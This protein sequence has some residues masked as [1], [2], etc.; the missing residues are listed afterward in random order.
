ML[1]FPETPCWSIISAWSP[2]AGTLNGPPS[3]AVSVKHF[4]PRRPSSLS[5]VLG[6]SAFGASFATPSVV[7]PRLLPAWPLANVVAVSVVPPLSPGSYQGDD[8]T[9]CSI[10]STTRCGQAQ[11]VACDPREQCFQHPF[12][13]PP[14]DDALL[15]PSALKYGCPHRCPAV[16]DPPRATTC[17][18]RP[19]SARRKALTSR[20]W[21]SERLFSRRLHLV[22]G[23]VSPNLRTRAARRSAA[24]RGNCPPLFPVNGNGARRG[25]RHFQR[26]SLSSSDGTTAAPYA[27]GDTPAVAACEL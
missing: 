13:P 24:E 15:S 23:A 27:H 16:I 26:S 8:V 19:R 4:R 14:D 25:L 5:S 11:Y 6:E 1:D 3:R 17:I 21:L 18:L 22:G 20:S 7:L 10:Q 2:A 12:F 9:A